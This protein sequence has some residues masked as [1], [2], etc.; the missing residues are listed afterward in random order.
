MEI[1]KNTLE[2]VY[3][4][5]QVNE[6]PQG[7]KLVEELFVD[8]SGMGAPDE[9]ALTQPQLEIKLTELLEAN[10]DRLE[11]FITNVGQ[12]QIYLGVYIK[13]QNV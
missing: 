8:N 9:I 4:S 2:K 11:T 10:N 1:T 5:E 13:T 7:L 3:K 6:T 12:F